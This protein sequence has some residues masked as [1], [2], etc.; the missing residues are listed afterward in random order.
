M[1]KKRVFY[2]LCLACICLSALSCG[3]KARN[4]K[5]KGGGKSQ[6]VMRKYHAALYTIF[7]SPP[8]MVVSRTARVLRNNRVIFPN[9]RLSKNDMTGM[10]AQFE[11][12]TALGKQFRIE[13]EV[14][15]QTET[16][17]K[18]KYQRAS[19]RTIAEYFR[20]SVA[21]TLSDKR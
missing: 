18:I 15:S 7:K 4:R 11:F 9:G 17:F 12:K 3:S 14:V 13:I 6:K 5:S 10:D 16:Q 20:S 8:S 21:A 19:D 2:L 1:K